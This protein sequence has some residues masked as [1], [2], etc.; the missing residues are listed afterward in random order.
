MALP[1]RRSVWWNRFEQFLPSASV[2]E[3]YDAISISLI[4]S[5]LVNED[6]TRFQQGGRQ[7]NGLV[8][9]GVYAHRELATARAVS[10]SLRDAIYQQDRKRG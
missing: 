9:E 3:M 6:A 2:I 4:T 7:N 5:F 1:N 8:V 10:K